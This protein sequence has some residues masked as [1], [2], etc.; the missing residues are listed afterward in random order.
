MRGEHRE[1][2]H[3]EEVARRWWSLPEGS[4]L[5][6]SNGAVYTLVFAGVPGGASGPDVRDAV[7]KVTYRPLLSA[8]QTERLPL[9]QITGDVEF[10]VRA[11]DWAV[12]GHQRDKRYNQVMLHVVFVREDGRPTYRQDGIMVPV[13]CVGDVTRFGSVW[14]KAIWPCHY[15]NTDE[16]ERGLHLAGEMRFEQKVNGLV[17]ALH[18]RMNMPLTCPFS[19]YDQV[20]IISL[21]EGLGYGRD[22]LF[23]R[24]V[25]HALVYG[26]KEGLEAKESMAEL[27]P[28]DAKRL[29]ALR[30]LVEAWHIG[31][32]WNVFQRILCAEQAPSTR[33]QALR[34]ALCQFGLSLAR[35]DILICNVILPFTVAFALIERDQVCYERAWEAYREHPGLAENWIT[36]FMCKQLTIEVLPD[37]SCQ[38]QGLQHIYQ[39]TCREKQCD[40]CVLGKRRWI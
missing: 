1:Y 39:Q 17:E 24:A 10:H 7:L 31:G 22:R 34:E 40:E 8:I 3:E 38:Q 27:A 28:L 30:Q 29:Q 20:L 9:M 25:G 35:T 6:A 16:L 5:P 13:C 2:V 14:R 18:M 37:G 36:R 15:L 4:A 11:S 32:A 19:V 12:H 21:A 33:L 23:F 26:E